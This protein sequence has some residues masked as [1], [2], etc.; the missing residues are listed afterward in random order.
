MFG[1]LM[2]VEVMGLAF[3][4]LS[5]CSVCVEEIKLIEIM[6]HGILNGR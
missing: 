2:V 5:L 6:C 1:R 3:G 4:D